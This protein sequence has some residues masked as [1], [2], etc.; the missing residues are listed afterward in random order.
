MSRAYDS[1]LLGATR[2]LPGAGASPARGGGRTVAPP[3]RFVSCAVGCAS[4]AG[5]T[6]LSRVPEMTRSGHT[7]SGVSRVVCRE[8]ARA[9]RASAG[10]VST[11]V[12]EG[13]LLRGSQDR[14]DDPGC[15]D[16]VRRLG[17]GPAVDVER[18]ALPHV[19]TVAPWLAAV[20]Q[21]QPLPERTEFPSDPPPAEPSLSAGR[22]TGRSR[23]G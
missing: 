3:V 4:T 5:G 18:D 23:R 13:E 14:P 1:G 6:R 2:S 10:I 21:P 11:D 12:T 9:T 17:R 20:T 8:V 22:G 7:G 16:G 15:A 19:S